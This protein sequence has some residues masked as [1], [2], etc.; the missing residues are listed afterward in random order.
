MKLHLFGLVLAVLLA[1]C[2]S[3]GPTYVHSEETHKAAV[4]AM[5]DE[6]WS[7]HVWASVKVS[8]SVANDGS[9]HSITVEGGNK[10]DRRFVSNLIENT[11]PFPPHNNNEPLQYSFVIN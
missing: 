8:F 9:I 11:A 3:T 5:I 10:Y 7:S 4:M 6:P 2:A 1:G